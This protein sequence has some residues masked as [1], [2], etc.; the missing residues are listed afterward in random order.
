MSILTKTVL[1]VHGESRTKSANLS[2]FTSPVH[3]TR[4][5]VAKAPQ[6]AIQRKPGEGRIAACNVADARRHLP[7]EIGQATSLLSFDIEVA[8]LDVVLKHTAYDDG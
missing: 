8:L 2:I 6:H 5:G 4:H 1:R 3:N 7:L